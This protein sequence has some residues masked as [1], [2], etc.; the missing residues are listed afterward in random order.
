MQRYLFTL[1]VI[2]AIAGVGI[3]LPTQGLSVQPNS[4][5]VFPVVFAS[6]LLIC[7]FVERAIE[8]FLSALRGGGADRLDLA[9]TQLKLIATP[10]KEQLDQ[11]GALTIS[12]SEYRSH[13]RLIAQQMGLCFGLMIALVGFRIL[14]SLVLE[15]PSGWQGKAFTLLDILLTGSVLAGGSDAVNKLTKAYGH[16]MA[17]VSRK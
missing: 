12:R 10:S 1:I 3:V 4:L 7:L 17:A 11:L 14:G 9:L 16:I 13:S 15:L 8:V 6:V 5:T 2:L